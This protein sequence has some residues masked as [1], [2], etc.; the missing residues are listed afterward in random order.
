MYK[1]KCIPW[2]KGKGGLCGHSELTKIKIGNSSRQRWANGICHGGWKHTKKWKKETRK[3]LLDQWKNGIRHGGWHRILMGTTKKCVMCDK[4]FY[5]APKNTNQKF[6]S[7]GCYNASKKG[8]RPTYVFPKGNIPWIKGKKHSLISRQKMSK[9]GKGKHGRENN[10]SWQG[11]KSFEPYGLE[12][13]EELREVV[14]NRDRRKCFI[15]EITELNCN[16]KL[17]VHHIDYD[18]KNNN[19]NNL[20]SLCRCCHSKTNAN[21]DYWVNYFKQNEAE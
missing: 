17:A 14:R 20:I 1:K 13:N 15:C 9:S 7:L 3:L 2:N 11:G 18:K 19:P 8:K 4:E 21:R 12:F 16:E 10:P 5:V 6:C